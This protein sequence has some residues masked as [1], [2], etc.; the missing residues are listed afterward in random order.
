MKRQFRHDSIIPSARAP[1]HLLGV[2]FLF[3]D[4]TLVYVGASSNILHRIG[5]H[6][7]A[8]KISF[9]CYSYLPCSINK[10]AET[11]E[12]YIQSHRPKYNIVGTSHYVE[13]MRIRQSTTAKSEISEPISELA[14]VEPLGLAI[15]DFIQ[16]YDVVGWRGT[17]T[18]LFSVL[19]GCTSKDLRKSWMWPRTAQELGCAINRVSPFLLS[20]GFLLRRK[21]S[22]NRMIIITPLSEVTAKSMGVLDDPRANGGAPAEQSADA[23]GSALERGR[24]AGDQSIGQRCCEA[25][26]HHAPAAAPGVG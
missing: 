13:N 15:L 8:G 1:A 9:N 5:Q 6:I 12:R 17:A 18:E 25:A 10:I 14:N 4:E 11:E 16:H 3:F 23:S 24:A 2:Y 20:N 22:I 7:Q 26:T 19:D 21:H